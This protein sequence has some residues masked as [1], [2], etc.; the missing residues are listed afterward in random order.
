MI[1]I[2][3]GLIDPGMT[4]GE[5][6]KG[7]YDYSLQHEMQF[8]GHEEMGGQHFQ[9]NNGEIGYMFGQRKGHDA[10]TARKRYFHDTILN[11]IYSHRVLYAVSIGIS[12][13]MNAGHVIPIRYTC[14][15]FRT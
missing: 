12:H 8:I 4:I 2:R 1:L 13:W 3:H 7:I 6:R 9:K 15:N 14:T 10:C 5:L 11:G